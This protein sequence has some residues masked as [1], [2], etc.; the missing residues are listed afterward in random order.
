MVARHAENFV[1]AIPQPFEEVAGLAELLGPRALG[2]VAADDDEVGLLRIDLFG[3]GFHQPLVMGTEVK[4]G[5]MDD[6]GHP[7]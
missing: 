4:V 2:E 7:G 3:N 6:P 5:E 1:A